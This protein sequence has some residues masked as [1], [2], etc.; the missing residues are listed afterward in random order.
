MT[1]EDINHLIDLTKEHMDQSE[2]A[3]DQIKDAVKYFNNTKQAIKLKS[4]EHPKYK[5]I[6]LWLNSL[7]FIN[8]LCNID[9]QL[10]RLLIGYQFL[11]ELLDL[12]R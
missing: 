11:K 5:D 2:G 12:L 1:A 7:Y 10:L 8:A 9:I 3:E 6:N 4:E